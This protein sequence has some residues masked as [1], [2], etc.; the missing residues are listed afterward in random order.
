[1][2]MLGNRR[3]GVQTAIMLS[4]DS[5]VFE[6]ELFEKHTSVR[7]CDL[8]EPAERVRSKRQISESAVAVPLRQSPTQSGYRIPCAL[9]SSQDG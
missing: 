9:I 2:D 8:Q 6:C 3:V 1:M 7:G 5:K 4:L